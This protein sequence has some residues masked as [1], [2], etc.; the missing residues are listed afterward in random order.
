MDLPLQSSLLCA[1]STQVSGSVWECRVN[2]WLHNEIGLSYVEQTHLWVRKQCR[3]VLPCWRLPCC[4]CR[5]LGLQALGDISSLLREEK[6]DVYVA[7]SMCSV[8][9]F[10]FMVLIWEVKIFLES[11]G[12]KK[13]DKESK[14]LS[15]DWLVFLARKAF[16]CVTR[17]RR[18]AYDITP[19]SPRSMQDNIGRKFLGRVP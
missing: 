12:S 6:C 13:K 16:F 17:G 19:A 15:H 1:P 7:L 2:V 8:T 10:L 9:F 5:A 4:I 14:Y 11:L 18:A 3:S